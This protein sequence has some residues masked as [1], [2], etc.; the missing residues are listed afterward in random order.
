MYILQTCINFFS[1]AVSLD[2]SFDSTIQFSLQYSNIGRAMHYK[3]LYVYFL[4]F[5]R[6]ESVIIPVIFKNFII[7]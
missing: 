5:V 3:I 2:L 4:D 1:T 6:S 7:L